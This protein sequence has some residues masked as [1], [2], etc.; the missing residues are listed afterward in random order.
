MI[1]IEFRQHSEEYQVF[2][3]GAS[4]KKTYMK[5]REQLRLRELSKLRASMV[6]E[7]RK[8]NKP[9]QYR[10]PRLLNWEN[11]F[12]NIVSLAKILSDGNIWLQGFRHL[13]A[14]TASTSWASGIRASFREI[15]W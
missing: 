15:P 10:D 3:D 9:L 6:V 13:K 12:E 1:E 2:R 11:N 7:M 14:F 8:L 4:G 5:V